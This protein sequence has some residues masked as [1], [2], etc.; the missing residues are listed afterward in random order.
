MLKNTFESAARHTYSLDF[1]EQN[2]G[3]IIVRR[4]AVQL[5]LKNVP[6]RPLNNL[7]HPALQ[8][9]GGITV[10]IRSKENE[11][12]INFKHRRKQCHASVRWSVFSCL[13]TEGLLGWR[14]KSPFTII[15]CAR[16]RL[17]TQLCSSI[18]LDNEPVGGLPDITDRAHT[19]TNN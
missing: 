3:V 19:A 4:V 18:R 8:T 2:D 14:Q 16:L 6:K 10:T 13:S 12:L 1:L 11:F 15:S 7:C 5:L 9:T 17:E